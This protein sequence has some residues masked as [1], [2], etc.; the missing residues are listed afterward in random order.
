MPTHVIPEGNNAKL[1]IDASASGKHR[2]EGCWMVARS[3]AT[4]RNARQFR[5]AIL[6]SAFRN[7]TQNML[8]LKSHEELQSPRFSIPCSGCHTGRNFSGASA[9]AEYPL[10]RHGSPR[11]VFDARREV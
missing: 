6:R 2:P 7:P 1:V 4:T 3:D 9:G 8:I 10:F 11:S 5:H